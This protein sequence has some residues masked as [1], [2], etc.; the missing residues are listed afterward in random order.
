[1]QER[2]GYRHSMKIVRY[3]T[4]PIASVALRLLSPCFVETENSEPLTHPMFLY[5]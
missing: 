5:I 1:M 4:N 3:C 2:L